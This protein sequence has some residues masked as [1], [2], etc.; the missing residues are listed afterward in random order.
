M[1]SVLLPIVLCATLCANAAEEPIGRLFFTPQQRSQLDRLRQS[2]GGPVDAADPD[3]RIITV[4]GLVRRSSGKDT[5]WINSAARDAR[6]AAAVGATG[7]AARGTPGVAVELPSGKRLSLKAGQTYD[8]ASGRV[9]EPYE[10]P[11]PAALESSP[12]ATRGK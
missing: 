11:L 1:R 6:D 4:N 2:N 10:D 12:P 8:P 9:S 5:A 7:R 3:S